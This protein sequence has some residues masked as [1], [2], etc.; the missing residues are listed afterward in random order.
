MRKNEVGGSSYFKLGLITVSPIIIWSS[1][2]SISIKRFDL[3][4]PHVDIIDLVYNF[5][6]F[7]SA[8]PR[9]KVGRRFVYETRR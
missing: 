7:Y 8:S 1:K 4:L 9:D 5:H 2:C 3:G 6:D